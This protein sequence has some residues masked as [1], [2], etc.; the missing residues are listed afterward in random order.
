MRMAVFFRVKNHANNK[1]SYVKKKK[2]TTI[3]RLCFLSCCEIHEMRRN[4]MKW[5][6]FAS[7]CEYLTEYTYIR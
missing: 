7:C 4:E 5:I 3:D 6:F 2:S 1:G